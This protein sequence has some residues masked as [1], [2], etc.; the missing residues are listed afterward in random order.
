MLGI[1]PDFRLCGGGDTDKIP[2]ISSNR[3]REGSVKCVLVE[4]W[5]G[6]NLA[7]MAS[8]IDYFNGNIV[9]VD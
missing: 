4:C 9:P 7:R 6:G 5:D 8:I 1:V 2:A 3:R